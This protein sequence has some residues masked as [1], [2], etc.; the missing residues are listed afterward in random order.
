MKVVLVHLYNH[1]TY[2]HDNI[3]NLK[4]FHNNDIIVITDTKFIPLFPTVQTI[5]IETLIHGYNQYTDSIKNSFRGGFWQLASFRFQALLQY[6]K[7]NDVQNI[8]HLEND[9]MLFKNLDTIPFHDTSKILLTMDHPSRCI[10]GIMFIPNHNILETCMKCFQTCKNDMENW[11]ISY[12]QNQ[13]HIDCL[14]IFTNNQHFFTKTF[15]HYNLI[16]DAAA[17]GQYLGGIDPRNKSGNTIG[18]VNETCLIDYS[19]F[20]FTWILNSDNI[21]TPFVTVD[22]KH[23]PVVN[24][25]VHSKNL[26]QFIK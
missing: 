13:N 19:K 25:H 12:Y 18:F 3:A 7:V 1:Q 11:A 22:N 10:P 23:I 2:I 6:M 4:R 17:I 26:K 9:V 21:Q 24:L 8:V 15:N 5:P 14:P 20:P 16:F